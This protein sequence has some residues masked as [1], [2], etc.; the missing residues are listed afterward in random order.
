MEEGTLQNDPTPVIPCGFKTVDADYT[1]PLRPYLA[2]IEDEESGKTKYQFQID[3]NTPATTNFAPH[4]S[5]LL[6]QRRDM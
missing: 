6:D 2:K 5:S 3:L 4:P 1:Y